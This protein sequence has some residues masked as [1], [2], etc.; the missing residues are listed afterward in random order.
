MYM[1]YR[2]LPDFM[3]SYNTETEN[4]DLSKKNCANIMELHN[5]KSEKQTE[6]FSKTQV[7]QDVF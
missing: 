4:Y 7:I 6:T 5:D 1:I 3:R 2:L